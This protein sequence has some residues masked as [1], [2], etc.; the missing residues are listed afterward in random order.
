[1]PFRSSGLLLHVTSLPSPFGVGDLG[2]G[3][4]RFVDYLARAGQRLW[5]VLP[6]VPAGLGHSP[7]ASPSTFAG[8][9][10]LISPERLLDD[11]L[12]VPADLARV[13]GFSESQVDYDRAVAFK[14]S[15][16]ERAFERFKRGE[17]A[18]L[19]ADFEQFC[20]THADW[21]EDYALFMALAEHHEADGCR[22]WAE[23]PEPLARRDPDALD[24]ARERLADAV[25]R[26]RLWQFLFDRQWTAL[27]AYAHQ[28]D[29]QVLGDLPIYVAYDS[30]DVWA[31]PHLFELDRSLQPIHVAGVPPDYFSATGQRWGNPLY[32]WDR[33][34]ADGFAWWV[35]RLARTLDL[36]D[37]V[38][39]DHFRAFE[40][41]WSIPAH[42]ETAVNGQWIE[43]PGEALF[44]ALEAEFGS[45]LPIVA[46]DLGLITPEVRALKDRFQLPG[47]VVLQFGFG[48]DA[49]SEYLPHNYERNVVAYTGTHDNDTFEGWWASAG[50][51]EKRF[52]RTYLGLER[53]RRAASPEAL[54]VL[55]ASVADTVVTPLQ[56]VL[57]LG[58]AARMNV[59]G[60]EDGNWA[61]RC[62][63]SLLTDDSA[64]RL[65]RL[66][67]VSGRL[68][69]APEVETPA[70][71]GAS[72]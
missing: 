70:N 71:P 16:L 66:T 47:M 11:G 51:A 65:R 48:G 67:R 19:Q 63:V 15:L 5:Q 30:A 14:R 24:D 27:R 3:A 43:A 29:V 56:D 41:Y 37:V 49:T 57:G 22:T 68:G 34:Q 33:M 60:Q 2:P 17:G 62:P 6:L 54:R 32:R 20:N 26:R 45:P 39:L 38:R 69:I 46:E 72:T 7:Y 23:W 52:A 59:P 10:L 31:H 44:K 35:R 4:Y 1:M 40:A 50:Q 25:E 36:V 9:P 64:D 8:N 61:W 18:S 28:R 21:L 58:N 42:E 53:S 55:M 13:P 12:L